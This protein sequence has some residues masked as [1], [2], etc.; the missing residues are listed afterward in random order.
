M[1]ALKSQTL[2]YHLFH[3]LSLSLSFILI[4]I[5]LILYFGIIVYLLQL[6]NLNLFAQLQI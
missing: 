6:E 1:C 5:T 4:Q 2:P 3:H